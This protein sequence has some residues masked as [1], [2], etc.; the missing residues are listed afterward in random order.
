MRN[1]LFLGPSRNPE[2]VSHPLPPPLGSQRTSIHSIHHKTL[3]RWSHGVDKTGDDSERNDEE[4]EKTMGMVVESGRLYAAVCSHSSAHTL[5]SLQTSL[6]LSP[7]GNFLDDVIPW[8]TVDADGDSS[9][10]PHE[11]NP[12]H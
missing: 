6:P 7:F 12:P 1:L 3:P 11:V 2:Y 8:Q 10:S 5:H 9:L 4:K